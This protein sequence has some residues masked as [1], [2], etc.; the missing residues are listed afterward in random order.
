MD[1]KVP[2]FDPKPLSPKHQILNPHL[3]AGTQKITTSLIVLVVVVI[4]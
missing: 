1:P 4:S 2:N 3:G